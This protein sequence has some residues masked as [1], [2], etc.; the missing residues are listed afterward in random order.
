MFLF[1]I[2]VCLFVFTFS[3]IFSLSLV[4]FSRGLK[5]SEAEFAE[6][7]LAGSFGFC[8]TMHN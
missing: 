7:L 1:G 2:F 4:G 6:T 8:V 3:V 5:L